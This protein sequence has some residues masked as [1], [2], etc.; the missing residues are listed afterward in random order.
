MDNHR[1]DP[2]RPSWLSRLRR[3]LLLAMMVPVLLF[4]RCALKLDEFLFPSLRRTALRPPVFI[5]GLPRSGTTYFHRLLA[6]QRDSFTT[7]PLWELLFAPALCEKLC[8]GGLYQ[9]L[10]PLR[11]LGIA[12]LPVMRR[13]G[14]RLPKSLRHIHPTGLQEPEEDFLSLLAYDGCFLR[15][16]AFPFS[17]RT[18]ALADIE[19]LPPESRLLLVRRYRQLLLRHQ[20]FRGAQY[21]I[22][23][24]NPSFSQWI[25][26]LRAEFPDADFVRLQRHPLEVVPSQLSS[27]EM[28]FSLFGHSARDPRI[29][30]ALVDMLAKQWHALAQFSESELSVVTYSQLRENP[31][32]A[33]ER[34]LQR[35]R[36]DTSE[37]DRSRLK[38]LC[39]AGRRYSSKHQYDLAS[40]GLSASEILRKFELANDVGASAG[41]DSIGTTNVQTAGLPASK[42]AMSASSASSSGPQL[43]SSAS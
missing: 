39:E 3:A 24:K 7:F 5:V 4:H 15:L 30:S 35:L 25:P 1:G 29:V 11:K 22:V 31:N 12:A 28:G 16:L 43:T 40:Y 42:D 36:V 8:L 17:P 41:A 34:I 2:P 6:S 9:V 38:L 20:L 21:R 32:K 19:T 18:W 37:T 33:T 10:V 27:L 26:S 13:I 14:C 23:S